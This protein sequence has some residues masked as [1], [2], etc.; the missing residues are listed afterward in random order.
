[1]YTKLPDNPSKEMILELAKKEK[2][3]FV[4]IQFTDLY[5]VVKAVTIPVDK[6]EA[7]IDD[8]VWFDGSS[9][10]GFS[11]I[12]ESDMYL[13]PDLKTFVVLP[14]SR[15][16]K[17]VTARIIG[18]VYTPDGKPFEGDPRYILKKVVAEADKM[19]Y[20]YFVGPEFEFFLFARDEKGKLKPLPHDEGGY[21]DQTTDMASSIR[22]AMA[23]NMK[24]VGLEVEALHHEVAQ[25]Q[26]EIG[27]KYNEVLKMADDAIT[28]RW[29]IK[30]TAARMGL[31]ATFMPKPVFGI[32]GS[33]MH[34]HQSLFKD[35]KNMFFDEKDEQYHLSELARQFMAGQLK[36]VR[37]MNA[38][39]DPTVN[40]YKR[41]VPGYEAPVYIA[42]ASRNR[43]ALI[44]I[45][46]YTKGKTQAT[47]C[48]LRCPDPSCNPYLAFAAMLATGL[49][50]IKGQYKVADAV[51]ENIYH[52][53]ERDLDDKGIGRLVGSLGEALEEFKKSTL[54][55]EVFGEHTFREYL[56][57]KNAEWDSYRLSV[58]HW[59]RE[60]YME[61][62]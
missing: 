24:E 29:V 30:E 7:V 11:R 31:H 9:I 57:A 23:Q 13:K 43:S 35:G 4:N 6:L 28:L 34:V 46:R 8:N 49:A 10:M 55:R 51:E 56:E 39:I 18:D 19:G 5:G 58:S 48:E 62:F 15:N 45:P 12:C 21:F 36:H 44:R 33:G 53:T 61:I 52:F 40:S 25:G 3:D 50:G 54:M 37:E 47:R 20:K 59:E 42:W 22:H 2:V 38:V 17:T 26:H 14:W 1:M 27:V 60:R 41:L 16:D 32:N